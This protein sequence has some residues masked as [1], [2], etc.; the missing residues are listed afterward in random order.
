MSICCLKDKTLGMVRVSRIEV[1]DACK[2]TLKSIY[3]YRSNCR[4]EYVTKWLGKSVKR[5]EFFW[6]WLGFKRPTRRDALYAY[7]YDGLHPEHM[8]VEFI[9]GLQETRCKEILGAV[10]FSNK[11]SVWMSMEGMK[12]CRMGI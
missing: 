8:D 7:Y 1:M 11:E 3:S 5:W 4:K 9:Y 2:A 12:F 10:S 6:C